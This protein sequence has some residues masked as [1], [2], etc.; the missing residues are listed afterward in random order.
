M[1]W[2][3]PL[4]RP[5]PTVALADWWPW[6][7][8]VDAPT[9]LARAALAAGR[10]GRL[11][12]AFTS[13]YQGA[14]ESMFGERVRG[15]LA[16]TERGGGHP[17]SIE[18]TLSGGTLAGTKTFV[19]EGSAAEV[20]WVVARTGAREGRPTLKV[21]R[22]VVG[23]PGQRWSEGPTPPFVPEVA[24]GVLHLNDAPVDRVLD[25]DG[26]L[27][28]VKPFRTVEDLHLLAATLGHALGEAARTE[29]APAWREDALS[30]LLSLAPLAAA[31]PADPAVHLPLDAVFRRAATVLDA[32]PWSNRARWARD[33]ALLGLARGIRARR[34]ERA[35]EAFQPK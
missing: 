6:H 27:Q 26:Y 18:T 31:D 23:G 24:H 11:A 13:G 29:S 17:R 32:A 9:P 3:T 5:Q 19:S 8:S 7:L 2:W 22:L 28:V 15:A 10:A 30:L 25:G 14:L 4:L 21:A 35:R 1:T 20:V 34:L 16:V 33:R 12:A